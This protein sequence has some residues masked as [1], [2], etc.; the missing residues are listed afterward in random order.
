MQVGN[1]VQFQEPMFT[2]SKARGRT[3]PFPSYTHVSAS[4][5]LPA[6]AALTRPDALFPY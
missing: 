1:T 4:P 5:V 2:D 6:F 3:E